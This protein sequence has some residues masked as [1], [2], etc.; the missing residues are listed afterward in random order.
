M[1]CKCVRE[2]HN[3]VG[4]AIHEPGQKFMPELVKN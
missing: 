4:K 2:W 3:V 1:I